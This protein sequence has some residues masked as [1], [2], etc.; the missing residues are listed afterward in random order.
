MG[1]DTIENA[2]SISGYERLDGAVPVAYPPGMDDRA[3]EA[4]RLLD[5]G[6]EALSEV[7]GVEPPEITAL[8]VAEEDWNHAPRESSRAYPYGLPYFTRSVRPPVLVLPEEVTNAITP[9]TEATAPLV[10]WHESA[11]AFLLRKEIVKTPT[12]LGEFVPQA[13]AAI[14]ARRAG[15]PL[16][17]H[18]SRIEA[19]PDFTVRTLNGRADAGR[20]MAFQNLL[21]SL[22]AAA[23]EPFGE[24]FLRRLVHRLWKETEVVDEI[25]AEELLAGSLGPGGRGWLESRPE[26]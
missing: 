6:I 21:L 12:W 7:L 16:G 2:A 5:T 25:R 9:R 17:E 22:A 8:L 18:L 11:H 23:L 4:Q 13:S 15:L 3:E 1:N 10:V 20:Q 24:E 19:D 26:F 14:V